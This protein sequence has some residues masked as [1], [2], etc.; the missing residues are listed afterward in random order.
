M[1]VTYLIPSKRS[2]DLQRQIWRLASVLRP[3]D[4]LSTSNIE[5]MTPA[6][7][8][9]FKQATTDIV[10]NAADDDDYICS[11]TVR[12]AEVMEADPSLD[13]LVTGGIKRLP[14][15]DEMTVCVPR[16]TGYGSCVADVARFG[17]CGSGLFLGNP[18]CCGFPDIAVIL[19]DSSPLGPISHNFVKVVCISAA[20]VWT[21]SQNLH[22]KSPFNGLK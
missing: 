22:V 9:A 14:D 16:G 20:L 7:R 4:R 13:V 6:L 5:G 21:S 3:N 15:G 1:G 11:G 19:D 8:D 2:E 17:A 12:A 10:R 18:L